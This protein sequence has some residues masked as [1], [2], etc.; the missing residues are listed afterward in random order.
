MQVQ[1]MEFSY[2]GTNG[3]EIEH[4]LNEFLQHYEIEEV[5]VTSAEDTVAVFLFYE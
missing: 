4:R 2:D 1:V 3:S 5:S